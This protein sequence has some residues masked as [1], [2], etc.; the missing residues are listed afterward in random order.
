MCPFGLASWALLWVATPALVAQSCSGTTIDP[1]YNS[2]CSACYGEEFAD[3]WIC[4]AWMPADG[5][6]DPIY[7]AC[8]QRATDRFRA[9]VGALPP[10]P[11][12]QPRLYPPAPSGNPC[13]AR[14]ELVAGGSG[15]RT[16]VSPFTAAA[17]CR[18]WIQLVDPVD[19]LLSGNDVVKMPGG[20]QA[21]ATKGRQISA[22]AADGL[23]RVVIKIWSDRANQQLTI[24]LLNES[25]QSRP[26]DEVGALVPIEGGA[27]AGSLS[28]TTVPTSEGPMAF[29]TY[30]VPLDYWRGAW[31]EGTSQRTVYFRVTSADD[32]SSVTYKD[33]SILRPPVILVH[34]HWDGWHLWDGFPL[35]ATQFQ[36]YAADYN[37]SLKGQVALDPSAPYFTRSQLDKATKSA[38]SFTYNAPAVLAFVQRSID[39]FREGVNPIQASAAAQADLVGHSMGGL[40][41]RAMQDLPAFRSRSS[42]GKG[43]LHK[44]ITFGTPHLGSPFAI[45]LL[46]DPCL[47]FG[48]A[49]GG[50]VAFGPAVQSSAGGTVPGSVFDLQ[51]DSAGYGMSTGLQGLTDTNRNGVPT[52]LIAGSM[53]RK[54]L[55]G[56][57]HLA[58]LAVSGV[59]AMQSPIAQILTWEGWNGIFGGRPNDGAVS[60]DS[61]LSLKTGNFAATGTIHSNG[62]LKIGF[63]GPAE[64]EAGSGIPAKVLELLNAPA[65]TRADGGVFF[66]LP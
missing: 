29:A 4:N 35:P 54:N 20:K 26:S 6:T 33:L 12:E 51:G 21:L 2:A 47:R 8:I 10:A 3:I 27:A 59:C 19:E 34:G 65:K 13:S 55:S 15:T 48:M 16:P 28:L 40:V 43:K 25:Q 11:P 30:V 32:S 46:Q 36:T 1:A 22:A 62:L 17:A 50:Q 66:T 60:V 61:Q 37:D 57:M 45:Q 52:A 49:Y 53:T 42:Y 23:T 56:L 14:G 63:S 24:E 31:D 38:L 9:C 18:I 39:D 41:A 44:I 58:G 64:V 5:P 7:Q